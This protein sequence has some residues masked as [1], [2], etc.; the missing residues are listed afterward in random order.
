MAIEA[1]TAAATTAG[2]GRGSTG[3]AVPAAATAPLTGAALVNALG[4]G[5]TLEARLV[6]L[7]ADGTARLATRLG[8]I[9]AR[10]A[11]GSVLPP[12]GEVVMLRVEAG[13][14]ADGQPLLIARPQ[15]DADP[16]AARPEAAPRAPAEV[17]GRAVAT[18]LAR[19]EG[20]GASLAAVER[21]V[22]TPGRLP[23]EIAIAAE[24]LLRTRLPLDRPPSAKALAAAA[25]ASGIFLE[26][27]LAR[28]AAPVAGDVKAALLALKAALA[29]FAT[30]PDGSP[31]GTPPP[32]T[33]PSPQAAAPQPLQQTAMPTPP[34]GDATAIAASPAPPPTAPAAAPPQTEPA[35]AALPTA[36]A[37]TAAAAPTPPTAASAPPTATSASPPGA[38]A[39]AAPPTAGPAQPAPPAASAA[40]LA[41]G[42]LS[43]QEVGDQPPP[44]PAAPPVRPDGHPTPPLRGSWPEPEAPRPPAAPPPTA[45]AAA[46]P[47]RRAHAGAEAALARLVLDQV[48]S[49]GDDGAGADRLRPGQQ[50]ERAGPQWTFELP[51]LLDGRSSSLRLQVERDG[52]ERRDGSPERR[53][54]SWRLRLA[55]AVEPLG[56]I[57]A[58]VGLVGGRVAVGIWAERPAAVA[59]LSAH[60]GTLRDALTAAA[61]DVDEIHLAAGLPP[62]A[63]RRAGRALLDATA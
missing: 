16:A 44:P 62:D 43:L 27:D 15:S 36:P 39:Q 41:F 21:L 19:Q 52:G 26:A 49:L 34:P 63:Q 50:S 30:P 54:A 7:L 28:A 17:V 25:R 6:A 48:A 4:A 51:V 5:A 57:R 8:P 18:A 47:L 10:A 61:F 59:A 9:V 38:P 42:L 20:L 46:E 58:Q 33:Q 13:A 22:A 45:E 23:P 14:A 60:V 53:Q 2:A 32:T 3:A 12:V 31:A 35:P 11:D 55:F 37:A 40:A 1:T 29:P 56:P 24:R